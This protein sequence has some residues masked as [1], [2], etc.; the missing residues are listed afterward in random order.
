MPIGKGVVLVGMGERT[1]RRPCRCLACRLFQAGAA[2]L[3]LAVVLPRSRHYMH[4]DTVADDG[5]P[6]RGVRLSRG[7]RGRLV[8]AAPGDS[9]DD[10]VLERQD[11]GLVESMGR[12]LGVGDMHVVTTGGDDFE[13]ERAAVGR[14]QQRAGAR[15]GRR[16]GLRAQHLH[17]HQAPQGRHRGHH[18]AR[19][20]ADRRGGA[21]R[22]SRPLERDPAY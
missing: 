20:R 2:D 6:R 17:Q 14:R 1:T 11:A 7:G 21:Y 3:V 18:H 10:V 22:L 5:R 12:H 13:A 4:L 9:P 15:A 16:R 8:W 19:L